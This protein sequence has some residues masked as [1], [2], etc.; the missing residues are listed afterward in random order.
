MAQLAKKIWLGH[1][2]C[3]GQ[4]VPQVTLQ[5]F[6]FPVQKFSAGSLPDGWIQ[7]VVGKVP[8]CV[9]GYAGDM[10]PKDSKLPSD[11]SEQQQIL[12]PTE[13]SGHLAT[14]YVLRHQI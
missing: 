4:K 6:A 7:P 12:I 1:S 5:S 8:L 2:E 3:D 13:V 14:K 9:P 11:L 10:S